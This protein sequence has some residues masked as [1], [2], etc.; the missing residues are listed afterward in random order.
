MNITSYCDVTRKRSLHPVTMTTV[1]RCL[2]LEFSRGVYTQT[3]T[4]G[5]TGSLHATEQ[6][7][8]YEIESSGPGIT[9]MKTKSSGAGIGAM[10][11]ERTPELEKGQFHFYDDSAA[12]VSLRLGKFA[13][14]SNFPFL[15]KPNRKIHTKAVADMTTFRFLIGLT[16]LFKNSCRNSF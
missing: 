12:L 9:P 1:G 3:V 4:P 7:P 15:N 10:F 11:M 13:P 6:E 2:I 8:C 5:I 16:N 14:C